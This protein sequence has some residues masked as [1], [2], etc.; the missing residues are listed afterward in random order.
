MKRTLLAAIGL[1]LLVSSASAD[2]IVL[3]NGMTIKDPISERSDKWV[4]VDVSGMTVTYYNDEI[5]SINGEAMAASVVTAPAPVK[6]DTIE[7]AQQTQDAVPVVV[8]QPSAVKV[9]TNPPAVTTPPAAPPSLP[10]PAIAP[11]DSSAVS[12]PS[13]TVTSTV[14][15]YKTVSKRPLK[16]AEAMTAML[17]TAVILIVGYSLFVYPVF[18]LSKKM[19]IGSPILAFIPILNLYLLTQLAGRPA[20]W[21]I[22]ML[23]PLLG[24]IAN[25]MVWMDIAAARNKPAWV[26]LLVLVPFLN[27]L[28]PWYLA[29]S[30]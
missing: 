3:K 22:L 10:P 14:G 16:P 1:V 21:M 24:L 17:I 30:S 27:L 26:G 29:L 13:M 12:S 8:S 6:H 7:L 25:A 9:S 28:V 2:E 11:S 5:T 18:L 4:K 23:V 20:W 19:Q 15:H